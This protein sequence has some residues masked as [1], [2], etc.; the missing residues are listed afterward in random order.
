MD[1]KSNMIYV[2]LEREEERRIKQ[3]VKSKYIN[4]L[5]RTALT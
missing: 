2:D 4:A 3:K 5:K 1:Y